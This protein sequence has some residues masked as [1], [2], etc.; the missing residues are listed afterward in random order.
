MT[1]VSCQARAPLRSPA[2]LPSEQGLTAAHGGCT[3][4]TCE[5][6]GDETV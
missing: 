5:Q 6:S 3:P 1:D 4:A 2:A